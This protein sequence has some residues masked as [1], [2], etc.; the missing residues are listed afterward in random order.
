MTIKFKNI[1]YVVIL[2]SVAASHFV[3]AKK[4]PRKVL[5]GNGA[6]VEVYDTSRGAATN[7]CKKAGHPP[8]RVNFKPTTSMSI[9]SSQQQGADDDCQW[10]P[11]SA[12]LPDC[13]KKL[14]KK[15]DCKYDPDSAKLPCS[16]TPSKSLLL[17]AVQAA[18][19]G[20][21]GASCGSSSSISRALDQCG[22]KGHKF[23]ACKKKNGN[24]SCEPSKSRNGKNVRPTGMAIKR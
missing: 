15:D 18:V 4:A 2:F 17:P 14:K 20:S 12:R 23:A 22:K 16:D 21:M 5:C 8:P 3:D 24:W 6:T 1:I 13:K 7:A 9:Q 10:D 11:N 19:G